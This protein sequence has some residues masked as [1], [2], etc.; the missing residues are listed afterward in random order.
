VRVGTQFGSQNDVGSFGN[1]AR[2]YL[3]PPSHPLREMQKLLSPYQVTTWWVQVGNLLGSLG[4][5]W[6]PKSIAECGLFTSQELQAAW[7]AP[8]LRKR[9]LHKYRKMILLPLCK[10][11]DRIHAKVCFSL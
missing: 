1:V 5:P 10:E 9:I 4:W 11:V 6:E 8:I 7:Y 2:L 3:L